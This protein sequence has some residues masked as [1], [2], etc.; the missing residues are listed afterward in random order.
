MAAKDLSPKPRQLWNNPGVMLSD[1]VLVI[2]GK[3]YPLNQIRGAFVEKAPAPKPG[4]KAPTAQP[5]KKPATFGSVMKSIGLVFLIVFLL[6][7]SLF[8]NDADS[9]TGGAKQPYRLVLNSDF[10]RKEVLEHTNRKKLNQ[11]AQEVNKK[12]VAQGRQP[13]TEGFEAAVTAR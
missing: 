8:W 1:S 12:L 2:E 11:I 4:E 13:Q 7:F 6:A 10:G 3:Y 9:G 5:V